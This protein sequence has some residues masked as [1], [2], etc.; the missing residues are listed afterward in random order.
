MAF[1]HR[2]H[3]H[4]QFFQFW[5][6]MDKRLNIDENKNIITL[7]SSWNI[8]IYIYTHTHAKIA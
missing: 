1:T 3:K 7:W 5:S 2:A 6:L 4:T 8:Y